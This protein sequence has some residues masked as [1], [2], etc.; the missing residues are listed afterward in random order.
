MQIDTIDLYQLHN[1]SA[2]VMRRG[3]IFELMDRVKREGKIRCYGVSLETDDD[4]VV[5]IRTGK[6]DA[7]QV[8][9]NILHQDP[10]D[11]LFPLALK[12]NVGII[13]RVPLERGVLSGRFTG[14]ETFAKGDFR[15][16][17]FSAQVQSIS[18]AESAGGRERLLG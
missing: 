13:A 4:G 12:E 3:E 1:P 14:P 15:A 9:Y 7:L 5:A 11:E 18:A 2:E 8:V 6:P 16:R 17:M 10:E